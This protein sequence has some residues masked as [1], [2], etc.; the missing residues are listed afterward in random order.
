METVGLSQ[1]K[2]RNWDSLVRKVHI[3]TDSQVQSSQHKTLTNH[4]SR[5]LGPGG[6]EEGASSLAFFF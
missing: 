6:K 2:Q 1:L 4:N 3:L 5:G